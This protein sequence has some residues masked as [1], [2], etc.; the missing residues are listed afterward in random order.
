MDSSNSP[1]SSFKGSGPRRKDPSGHWWSTWC[2]CQSCGDSGS[3][4][5]QKELTD[6]L[7]N[8]FMNPQL[9]TNDIAYY[10]QYSK[11]G[12]NSGVYA[13]NNQIIDGQASDFALKKQHPMQELVLQQHFRVYYLLNTNII[14]LPDSADGDFAFNAESGT[15]WMQSDNQFNSGDIVPDQV[16]PTSDA[17]PLMDSAVGAA[18]IS[19]EYSRGDHQ[20][21]LQISSVQPS[22][23]TAEGEAGTANTY[24]RSDHTHHGNLSNDVPLKDC[25]TG[26]AG[27]SNICDSAQHQHPLN[28]DPTVANV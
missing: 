26:T 14:Q 12:G 4:V 2:W 1:Q 17:V 10:I 18:G 22:R 25:G 3:A 15:V 23:D 28:I 6:P 13:A 16:T 20:H 19:N 27:T 11:R 24:A 21:P 8:S 7:K 9:I 5:K